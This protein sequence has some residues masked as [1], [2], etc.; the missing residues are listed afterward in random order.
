MYCLL[1]NIQDYPGIHPVIVLKD[2]SFKNLQN[3]LEFMYTGEVS[4]TQEL[5]PDFLKTAKCLKVSVIYIL[6]SLTKSESLFMKV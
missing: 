3:I 4:I 2:V 5:L 6:L 1:W